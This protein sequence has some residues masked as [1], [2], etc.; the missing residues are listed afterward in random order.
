[1]RTYLD[2]DEIEN[3]VIT[4]VQEPEPATLPNDWIGLVSSEVGDSGKLVVWSTLDLIRWRQSSALLRKN[5]EFVIGRIYRY[6]I[7]SGRATIRL[8]AYEEIGGKFD[9]KLDDFVR[10]NDPLFLMKNSV[11]PTPFDE[12]PA[13][14]LFGDPQSIEVGFDGRCHSVTIKASICKTATHKLG[15]SSE[16]RQHPAKT[17]ALRSCAQSENWS[18]TALSRTRTIRASGGGVSR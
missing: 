9:N 10:P 3:G 5:A 6:F 7:N 14:E 2:L 8:G 12:D 17:L 16:I 13:F 18:S 1:M 11:A 4:E 15:G